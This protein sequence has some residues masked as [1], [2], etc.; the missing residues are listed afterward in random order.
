MVRA[1]ASARRG[2]GER[3]RA[4]GV[5]SGK[6]ILHW[7]DGCLESE[8]RAFGFGHDVRLP[9]EG[10]CSPR[11]PVGLAR[12]GRGGGHGQRFL[13]ASPPLAALFP[14][15]QFFIDI[16]PPG[17]YIG[18]ACRRWHSV[19]PAGDLAPWGGAHRLVRSCRTSLYSLRGAARGTSDRLRQIP[20]GGPVLVPCPSG[21][22][23]A[24]RSASVG[25][26]P[27]ASDQRASVSSPRSEPDVAVAV[28]EDAR[29]LGCC[30]AGERS[31]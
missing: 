10:D 3:A 6:S 7:R 25:P 16:K 2:R 21:L 15:R 29:L 9:P 11:W 27:T 1:V 18:Q 19:I 13:G 14:I 8:R 4:G 23:G 30:W 22:G 17:V 5:S 28:A 26:A 31:R 12:A 24:G 20:K